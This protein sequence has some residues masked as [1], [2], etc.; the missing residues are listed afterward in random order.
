MCV[1][2]GITEEEKYG[3]FCGFLLNVLRSLQL[4]IAF[5]DELHIHIP[6]I[7]R[8]EYHVMEP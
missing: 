4:K 6:H 5:Q 3:T 7:S 8:Q 2:F 1:G